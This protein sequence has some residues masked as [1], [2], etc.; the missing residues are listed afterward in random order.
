MIEIPIE[1]IIQAIMKMDDSDFKKV[2]ATVSKRQKAKAT[3]IKNTFRVGETVMV[4]HHKVEGLRFTIVKINQKNIKLKG[5]L[6]NR[7][8]NVSPSLLFKI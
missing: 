5:I 2:V 7:Q 8:Y 3:S 4:N 6:N 1:E